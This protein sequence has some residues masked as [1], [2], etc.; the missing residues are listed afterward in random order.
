MTKNIVYLFALVFLISCK[1]NNTEI[2]AVSDK[3]ET[4]KTEFAT[5]F[6]VIEYENYNVISLKKPWPNAD[7]TFTYL[8]VDKNKEVPE[9]VSY[10]AL[11]RVPVEKIVVTST[12][13]IPALESLGEI[14]KLVGFPNTKF[15]S[16][17]AARKRV[18]SGEIKELG[19]N[20][21][22]NTEVLLDIQPDVVV[23]FAVNGNNKTFNTIQKAG[24]PV[25]YNAAWIEQHALGRAEW[26]KFFGYLFK[27]EAKANT[28]F[29]KIVVD[30]KNAKTLAKKTTDRP[31][32]LAGSMFKDVWNVPYGNSW[33]A[34]FISD[35]GGDYLWAES[36]GSGSIALNIESVLEKA[37]QADCWISTGG[38]AD[39]KELTDRN[40][41]YAQFKAF[42]D[43]DTYIANRKGATGG[44][45]FYEL[46]PNRPDLILKDLIK[47][48]HPELLPNHE[49]FFYQKIK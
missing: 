15:I 21:N 4:I 14:D 6:E 27:K 2:K 24:I 25:L 13:H 17:E 16:S 37:Q 18:D 23:G 49:L 30:Y 1:K 3:G 36:K 45:L 32:V 40:Q 33:V 31:T 20:E 26:V 41:H 39:K 22:I 7:K 5:G 44:L 43:N 46:G 19:K 29:N 42:Q 12:T 28:V 10:D 34:Q 9:N 38:T 47:I 8:L 48:F 35:A 11:V